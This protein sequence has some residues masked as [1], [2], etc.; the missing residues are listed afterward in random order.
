MARTQECELAGLDAF[1]SKPLRAEALAQLWE[2][3]RARGG[4]AAQAPQHT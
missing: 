2:S 3:A 4:A 1:L